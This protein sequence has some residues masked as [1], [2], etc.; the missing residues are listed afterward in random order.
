M[1]AVLGLSMDVLF[2]TLRKNN[3]PARMLRYMAEGHGSGSAASA[4]HKTEE[5]KKWLETYL[6]GR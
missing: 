4:M 5:M 3:V 1:G 6:K 2:T